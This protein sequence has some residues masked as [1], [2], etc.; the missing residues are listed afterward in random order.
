MTPQADLHWAVVLNAAYAGY[1]VIRSLA[2]HGM[3]IVTFQKDNS[4]PETRTKLC[5]EIVNFNNDK[6]LLTQLIDLSNRLEKKPV[7]YITSDIHV[8]FYV[9]HRQQLE[10]CFLI[11]YP[12]S[13]VVDLLH[14]KNKFTTYAIQHDLPIPASFIVDDLASLQ[15]QKDHFIFPAVLKPFVKSLVWLNSNL[16][17]AYLVDDYPALESLYKKIMHVEA[18]LLVQEFIPGPDSNVEYCLSYFDGSS[19]S[20]AS[21]VGAKIRQWPLTLGNTASTKPTTNDDIRTISLN[22]FAGLNYKGFG[23]VE[24]K[25]HEINNQYYIMEPTVGR[26]NLQSYVATA[27]GINMPIIAYESLTGI[28]FNHSSML[29]SEPITYVDEWADLA[30]ILLLLKRKQ[31]TLPACIRSLRGKKAY[32]YFSRED[33]SVF[34]ASMLAGFKFALRKVIS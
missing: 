26:P 23:S 6:E 22:L 28:A 8:E 2:P 5:K 18:N 1:G 25:R 31:T 14:R 15:A 21:F 12:S 13:E 33:P 17:K 19:Q 4:P 20:L 10:N 24:F 34:F 11:H 7:L 29:A 30:S 16:A 27:N 32:R 3:P 9:K